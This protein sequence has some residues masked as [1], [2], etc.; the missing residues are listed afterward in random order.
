M[1]REGV[2]VR[3]QRAGPERRGLAGVFE[4]FLSG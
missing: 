1:L 3:G 4:V 2:A